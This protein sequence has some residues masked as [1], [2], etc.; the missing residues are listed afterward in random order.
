MERTAWKLV[1]VMVT[2][3]I[4]KMESACVILVGRKMTVAQVGTGMLHVL[5]TSY[6]NVDVARG[7]DCL[8]DFLNAVD[9]VRCIGCLQGMLTVCGMNSFNYYIIQCAIIMLL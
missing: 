9:K 1:T 3:V 8:E 7:N 5:L 2:H 6:P 4:P